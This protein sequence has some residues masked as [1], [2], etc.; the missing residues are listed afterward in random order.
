MY[1][2]DLEGRGILKEMGIPDHLSC[3]LQSLH[4]GQ[5]VTVRTEHLKSNS[6]QVGKDYIKAVYNHFAYLT[7]MQ[8]TSCEMPDWK[9]TS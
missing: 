3:L 6:F 5:E 7:Y 4:A 1:K 9:N 8:S 2:L